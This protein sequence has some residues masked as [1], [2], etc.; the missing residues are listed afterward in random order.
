MYL[1]IIF[2]FL[3]P[4]LFSTSCSNDFELTE[5]GTELPVVYGLLSQADTAVYIR[6]EK[7]FLSEDVEPKILAQDPANF[8][9]NDI[10]VE[11]TNTSDDAKYLLQRVNGNLEGYPRSEGG[12]VTDPN[13]IYKI[14]TNKLNGGK[15]GDNVLYELQI[16]KED[17]TV[18]AKANTRTLRAMSEKDITVPS[19]AGS[20][21][22]D[23]SR[24][25]TVGFRSDQ[26]AHIHDIYLKVYYS[27]VKN[28]VSEEKV[29]RWPIVKNYNANQPNNLNITYSI[30]GR[31]FYEFLKA[32]IE[33]DPFTS[34]FLKS[35]AIE[36]SSGGVEIKD[37][38]NIVQA[39]LGITSSGEV[40][41]YTNIENG[42]GL[43]S[44]RSYL[45]RENISFTVMTRDSVANGTITKKLNFK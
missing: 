3:L 9:Y 23:Y 28:G 43:F 15:L 33:E 29:L 38:I 13:Y 39:N 21:S 24:D 4:T 18:L 16:K 7:T 41:S 45:T 12:F 14:H 2:L 6:I 8:Y 25:F 17:G 36:I 5:L 10:L 42:I 19:T 32:N 44:S 27:E 40:P 37:Y 30:K 22:F 1:R 35:G 11:L 34:R 20:L 26:N 31:S